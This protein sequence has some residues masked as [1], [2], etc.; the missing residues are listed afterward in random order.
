MIVF[1]VLWLVATGLLVWVYTDQERIKKDNADLLA[2]NNLLISPADQSLPAYREASTGSGTVVGLLEE[3]RKST[4][5]LAIGDGDAL[6]PAVQDRFINIT[7]RIRQEG[8][9]TSPQ[10]FQP[11]SLMTALDSLYAA[12]RALDD[13]LTQTQESN[14]AANR[15]V[16]ELIAEK[17][18]QLED[19]HAKAEEISQQLKEIEEDWQQYRSAREEQIAQLEE[20]RDDFKTQSSR[21]IQGL[22]N[23]NERLEKDLRELNVRFTALQE[24]LGELQIT[25]LPRQTLQQPDGQVLTAKPGEDVVYIDLGRDAQLTLGLQFAV[26]SPDVGIPSDGLSKARIEVVSIYDR[27]AACKVVDVLGNSLILEGD[28]IANPI[29][30]RNRVL[31][32]FVMG[33]FDLDNNKKPDRQG[34]E[35]VRALIERWGGQVVD[36]VSTRTD[37]V[38]VGT[39]PEPPV[40]VGEPTVETTERNRVIRE[41]YERFNADLEAAQSIAIPLLT[42]D[43]FLHFLGY[44]TAE[45]RPID[46]P[47]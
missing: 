24:K 6:P 5:L 1:V 21:N 10:A 36:T 40:E 7:D 45:N 29:Y 18:Q 41:A 30:D 3:A 33:E 28:L 34:A 26:Y 32:F 46:W 13:E 38:V 19:F 22:R 43:V 20:D 25:P 31:E 9:L 4:A 44:R 2:E 47:S 37:F 23:Q 42:Q 8:R 16:Q 17:E 12:Y 15:Q 14:Q 39:A 27:S 11:D 35:R